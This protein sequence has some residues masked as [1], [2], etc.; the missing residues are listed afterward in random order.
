MICSPI[1]VLSIFLYVDNYLIVL[2]CDPYDLEIQSEVL[3]YVFFGVTSPFSLTHEL[4]ANGQIKSLDIRF[5]FSCVSICWC[6]EPCTKNH[7]YLSSS[8]T[9]SSVN[10]LLSCSASKMLWENHTHT[11][12]LKHLSVK[13]QGRQVLTPR[14]SPHFSCR[15]PKKV[16]HHPKN[17]EAIAQ[18]WQ[19]VALK[20]YMHKLL[21][22]LIKVSP[23]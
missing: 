12:L 9:I 16:C 6:Y 22:N 4:P 3:L 19:K 20:L 8:P 10:E 11:V 18:R 23:W 15:Q 21:P 13:L 5:R 17:C 2:I 14:A 7:Y 1:N